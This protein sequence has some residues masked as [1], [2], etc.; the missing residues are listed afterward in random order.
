MTGVGTLALDLTLG[1]A[2]GAAFYGGLWWTVSRLSARKA[3]SW[4]LGSFAL[5]TAIVLVGF[6]SVARTPWY[7][8]AACIVGFLAAR[9]AVTHFTRTRFTDSA[10]TVS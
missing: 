4:L 1:S 8:W 9:V 10:D 7:G 5:R 3:G 2:L 6:Y